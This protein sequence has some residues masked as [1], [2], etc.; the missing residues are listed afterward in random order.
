MVSMTEM[1]SEVNLCCLIK[2]MF[3]ETQL[4]HPVSET[5][6]ASSFFP[7]SRCSP[8]TG[9]RQYRFD[10]MCDATAA[11]INLCH[12]FL[13]PAFRPLASQHPYEANQLTAT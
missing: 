11:A 4:I 3:E 12:L 13:V 5:S 7:N 2:C 8:L 9:L 10:Q 6:T 1:A